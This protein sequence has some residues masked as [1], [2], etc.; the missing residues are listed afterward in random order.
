[1]S[2]PIPGNSGQFFALLQIKDVALDRRGRMEGG[3]LYDVVFERSAVYCSLFSI[4]MI[5]QS[6][7][8]YWE[9]YL[10]T[11]AQ[12]KCLMLTISSIA[13]YRNV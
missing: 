9:R 11:R 12:N 5:W 2:P 6:F 3:T 10:A 4:S 13:S 7:N 1:M 8:D